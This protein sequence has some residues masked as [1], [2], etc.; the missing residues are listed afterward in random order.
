MDRLS[1]WYNIEYTFDDPQTGDIT[2]NGEVS[3]YAQ[4]TDVIKLLRLTSKV[5]FDIQGRSIKIKNK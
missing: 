3:R 2:F 1:R 5:T 4:V